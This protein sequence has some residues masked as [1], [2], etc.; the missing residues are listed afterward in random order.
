MNMAQ[1]IIQGAAVLY[2]WTFSFFFFF[3]VIAYFLQINVS[4]WL[5]QIAVND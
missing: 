3:F 2:S 4:D 5:L 1:V